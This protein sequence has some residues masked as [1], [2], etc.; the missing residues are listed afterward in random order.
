MIA[1]GKLP[2]SDVSKMIRIFDPTTGEVEGTKLELF[3][4]F[5]KARSCLI[6]NKFVLIRISHSDEDF[7]P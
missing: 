6:D 1:G 4:A 2:D 5:E 3:F 7:I